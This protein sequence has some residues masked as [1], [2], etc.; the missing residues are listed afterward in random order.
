MSER[1]RFS[2]FP[3]DLKGHYFLKSRKRG[4]NECTIT[5]VSRKGIGAEFHTNDKINVG[6]TTHVE[7]SAPRQLEPVI[8]EGILRWIKRRQYNFVGGIELIKILDE[9]TFSKLC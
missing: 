1:R 2:R 3:T 5:D 6:S 9:V 8:L 4:W 7:I